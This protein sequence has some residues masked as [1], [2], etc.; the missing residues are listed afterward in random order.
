[1]GQLNDSQEHLKLAQQ[2]FQL[3]GASAS[4][5]DTIPG[6]QCMA[7]CFFLLKQFE[8]VL[9]YLNSV[10]A[11]SYTDGIFSYN[12]GIAQAA[13]GQYNGAEEALLLVMEETF[14]AEYCYLSW[15]A[16]CFI[17]NGKP[18][19]A[20]ELYLKM[21][22]NTDSFAM[23]VLISNDCYKVGSFFYAAK[24]FDVLERLDPSPEYWEGKRGACCGVFQQVYTQHITAN[25]R[26]DNTRT[27][28]IKS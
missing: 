7:S 18:R 22:S 9:I 28:I 17:M 24:A 3:V 5:C 27:L 10:K 2:F 23:L 15:L 16:R 6:R 21:E 11:Y 4:E 19:D 12:Y 8:D 1:M 14:R 25:A 13:C 26:R 20:W